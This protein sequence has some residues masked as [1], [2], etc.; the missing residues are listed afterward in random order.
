V[1]IQLYSALGQGGLCDFPLP[2][3]SMASRQQAVN[4]F[5]NSKLQCLGKRDKSS[6]G[7]IDPKAV[8]ICAVINKLEQYYT[9]S[10]CAGRCFLYRG[11]GVKSTNQFTRFRVS[12]EKICDPLRY[13]NLETLDNDFT[14]GGDPVRSVGQY[15]QEDHNRGTVQAE[16]DEILQRERYGSTSIVGMSEGDSIWLR[17]E[18]FILHVAC[19]SL[20]A[21]SALMAAAR[22][23]FKNVGLT[24]WKQNSRYLVAIWGDEGL[25]MPLSIPGA[26]RLLI[27]NVDDLT[28]LPY[29]LATLVNER[30]ERN[31]SKIIRF[32]QA[33]RDM[34]LI[35][36]DSDV[37]ADNRF[38]LMTTNQNASK[39]PRSFDVVGDIALIHNISTDDPEERKHIGDAIMQKN[40]A[41]KIVAV[42]ESSLHGIERAPGKAGVAIIAGMQRS[43][44][45]TTHCEYGIKCVVD[46]QHTFFSPRMGPERLRI[47][48]QVARG[49]N[50]L[51]LFA[52]VCMDALQIAGRTEA[53]TILAVDMNPIATECGTRA[54]RMLVRNKAVKTD[55]AADRLR[56]I[57]GE[58]SQVLERLP[59]N[60][61]DRVLAP[62]PKEGNMDGDLGSGDGG[63]TF[64]R[65][66][67]PVMNQ[68]GGECHW[69]DFV[70]DH[71]FPECAR[72][73]S[74]VESVCN[75][76]GLSMEVLHVASVGSVA[77]RQLRICLDFR[78][79]PMTKEETVSL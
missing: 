30:H 46:L 44:L 61:F 8:D 68:N 33:V 49:E 76:Q 47:C 11:P 55:G 3:H 2:H 27:P 57:E 56:I 14:G 62:R 12:H 40:K 13:F 20:A 41:I 32:T 35:N 77:M 63:I 70:A 21:A 69:Y 52:G 19:R 25:D 72:T 43:P 1:N 36:D 6:A 75:H 26:S 58:V 38:L 22:P 51:V 66:F 48:Q 9:T 64:L 78:I 23:A 50:V 34:K 4:N 18:P 79:F 37:E 54:L 74:L 17:F 16:D 60:F 39:I 31:W 59:R 71:E 73:R 65:A 45:I 15:D 42:R 10:S 28:F 29:W 24:T 53:S 5:E 67:L 7:R